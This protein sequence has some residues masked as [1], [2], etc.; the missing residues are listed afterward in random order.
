MAGL[1]TPG[2]GWGEPLNGSIHGCK[3]RVWAADNDQA[4]EAVSQFLHEP[5]SGVIVLTGGDLYSCLGG[6]N[7]PARADAGELWVFACDVLCVEW[8]DNRELAISGLVCRRPGR[9]LGVHN[10]PIYAAM[11]PTPKSHPGDGRFEILEAELGRFEY[12]EML[13]RMARGAHLP[14]PDIRVRSSSK[15][16][17]FVPFGSRIELDG[18]PFNVDKKRVR[19][20]ILT[21][22]ALF[23][24]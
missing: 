3:P 15:S 24:V 6:G 21:Q 13:H 22:T 19:V 1:I 12:R 23:A 11:N 8:D 7:T 2:V 20:S 17:E 10:S 16:H 14:H 9:Y 18:V 4:R 5:Q